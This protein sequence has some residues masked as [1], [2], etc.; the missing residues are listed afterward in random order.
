MEGLRGVRVVDFTTQ[1]AGPY[2]TKLFADAGADIIK[3]ESPEGDPLRGWTISGN[4]VGKTGSPLFRFLNASKRSMT[5][6]HT[7]ANVAALIAEADLVVEDFG[8]DSG[9]NRAALLQAHPSL[10]LLSL[11]PFGLTGPIRFA[12]RY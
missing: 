3:V 2:C 5:G 6:S 12:P 7:D 9:F 1:I 4:P 11:S 8:P 10:V